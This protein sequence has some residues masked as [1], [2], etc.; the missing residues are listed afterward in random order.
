MSFTP[1][2]ANEQSMDWVPP[3]KSSDISYTFDEAI[4]KKT[5]QLNEYNAKLNGAIAR[6]DTGSIV[7]YRQYIKHIK[8]ELFDFRQMK[9]NDL[10]EGL[11][12]L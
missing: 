8:M 3:N 4:E 2:F 10:K 12:N 7:M 6:E 5:C 11:P 9:K 1:S